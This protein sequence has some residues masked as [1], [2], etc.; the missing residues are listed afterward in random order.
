M[1]DYLIERNPTLPLAAV[2]V[3]SAM[4]AGWGYWLA[5]YPL[6]VAKSMMQSEPLG[7]PFRYRNVATTVRDIYR[8]HG[9]TALFPG[10]AVCRRAKSVAT[11]NSHTTLSIR[12]DSMF[13]AC[14]SGRHCNFYDL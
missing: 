8:S 9:A 11:N 7:Q 6:D 3:P 10:L 14:C 12:F 2:Q 13:S 5:C 1:K 4:L